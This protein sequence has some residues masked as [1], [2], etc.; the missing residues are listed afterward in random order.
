[1][2]LKMQEIYKK[3]GE[4]YKPKIKGKVK[5]YMDRNITFHL[6]YKVRLVKVDM[7]G[8]EERVVK[9]F[10]SGNR[11]LLD[12]EEFDEVYGEHMDK[13]NDDLENYTGEGS[14]WV[15]EQIE[16]LFLQISRYNPIRGSSYIPTPK[17]LV[18]KMAIVNVQNEDQNCFL[19]SVLAYLFPVEK[20]QRE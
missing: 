7:E 10:N 19:Y 13:L 14:G 3:T 9:H 11:R 16:S 20:I 18:K 4:K 6:R 8:E 17:G 5:E 15:L 2:N 12:M 1:M